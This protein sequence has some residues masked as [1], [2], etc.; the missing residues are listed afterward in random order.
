VLRQKISA[1]PSLLWSLSTFEK[2][3]LELDD[4]LLELELDDELLELELDDELLELELDDELLEL[5]LELELELLLEEELE[6]TA[7]QSL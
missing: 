3:P 4:E 7:T 5:E 2:E 1:I 6:P